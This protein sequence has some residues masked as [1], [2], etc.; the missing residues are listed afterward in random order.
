MAALFVACKHRPPDAYGVAGGGGGG[1]GAGIGA[2]GGAGGGG[3]GG[4]GGS[5]AEAPECWRDCALVHPHGEDVF[6]Q[7]LVCTV[8]E[9]CYVDCA[10]AAPSAA[11]L[12]CEEPA[13]PGACDEKGVCTDEDTIATNDCTSCALGSACQTK[14]QACQDDGDCVKFAQCIEPCP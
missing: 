2:S 4:G 3:V 5:G 7:L 1:G 8:C 11:W 14:L 12:G 9:Q 13:L 6:R 10:G